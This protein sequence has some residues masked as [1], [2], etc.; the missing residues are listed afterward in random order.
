[1]NRFF[2]VLCFFTHFLW[3]QQTDFVDFKKV[4]S[5]LL[6]NQMRVDST[7]FNSYEVKFKIL[8]KTDSIY[9]DAI[10]MKF[11]NVALNGSSIEYKNDGKKLIIYNKF[12]LAAILFNI[13][14]SSQ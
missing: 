8:K 14:W 10:N 13:F 3:A 7:I 1:M 2:F 5:V 9:L 12:E 4:E 11:L 6:F